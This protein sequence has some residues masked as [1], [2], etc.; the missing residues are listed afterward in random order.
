[1]HRLKTGFGPRGLHHYRPQRANVPYQE[2]YL[3]HVYS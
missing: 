1:M 2:E 3:F